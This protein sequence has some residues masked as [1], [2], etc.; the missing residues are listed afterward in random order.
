MR[1]EPNPTDDARD[2]REQMG[3]DSD[4][5][6][7]QWR[8]SGAADTKGRDPDVSPLHGQSYAQGGGVDEIRA[9]RAAVDADPADRT[10]VEEDRGTKP[11]PFGDGRYGRPDEWSSQQADWPNRPS[12]YEDA[13]SGFGRGMGGGMYWSG[14]SA[15]EDDAMRG[16]Y[17]GRGPRGYRRTDARIA[18]DASDRLTDDEYVDASDVTVSVHDAVVTLEGTIDSAEARDRAGNIARSCSGVRD[19]ENRIAVRAAA[20]TPLDSAEKPLG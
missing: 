19:V 13:N 20:A 15:R 14:E 3:G 2:Q 10:L 16:P 5:P 8:D 18:E 11:Q 9:E 12:R 1:N 4:V 7:Y 6:G 17:A